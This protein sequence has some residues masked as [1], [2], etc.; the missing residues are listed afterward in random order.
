MGVDFHPNSFRACFTIT[1]IN[2][3]TTSDDRTTVL[4]VATENMEFMVTN[5]TTNITFLGKQ[6]VYTFN[7]MAENSTHTHQHIQNRERERKRERGGV[8][9]YTTQTHFAEPEMQTIKSC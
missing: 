7:H 1:I 2:D 9:L 4:G 3:I 8:G 6:D 5:T